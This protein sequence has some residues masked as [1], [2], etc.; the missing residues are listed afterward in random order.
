MPEI[1]YQE[2]LNSE[3]TEKVRRMLRELPPSC[4]DFI[5]SI[6]MTTSPLTRM[7]Y[8][9]D[10]QTFCSYAVKEIPYF[11]TKEP[12]CWTDEDLARFTARDLNGWAMFSYF[13]VSDG[14]PWNDLNVEGGAFTLVYPG[15]N[16]PVPTRQ[17][18]AAREAFEDYLLMA[19]LKQR[20]P[21]R[22]A[23]V[24]RAWKDEAFEYTELRE[25]IYRYLKE[26]I[27]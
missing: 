22:H 13:N 7:A 6:T 26:S 16:G 25:L 27:R 9:I 15:P 18:M 1:T 17:Y 21:E 5:N 23:E 24:L 12:S 19:L 11:S 14:E 10:L 8:T 20:A 2:R 4:T 3:R